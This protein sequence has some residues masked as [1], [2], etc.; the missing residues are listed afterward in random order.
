MA[1]ILMG[2]GSQTTVRGKA[3]ALISKDERNEKKSCLADRFIMPYSV[4]M[5]HLKFKFTRSLIALMWLTLCCEVPALFAL[6]P[7]SKVPKILAS[8]ANGMSF[9]S[10]SVAGKVVYV[11]FWASWCEPCKR[12]LPWMNALQIK[13]KDLGLAVIA[14][15]LDEKREDADKLLAALG[16]V[17]FT[18]LFDSSGNSADAFQVNAMPSSYLINRQGNVVMVES[19]FSSNRVKLI[20]DTIIT[21]LKESK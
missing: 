4:P 17:A 12:S 13:H 6:E 1:P 18:V 8:N 9:D 21:L 14:I 2:G 10:S 5:A 20:E 7:G 11:D 16:P 15:N 19:G 3:V